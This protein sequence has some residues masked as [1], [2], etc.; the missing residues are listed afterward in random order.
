[1]DLEAHTVL[2]R[3]G[4]YAR[5]AQSAPL[6][7]APHPNISLHGA[8][9]A[10]GMQPLSPHLKQSAIERLGL[11]GPSSPDPA[12]SEDN[13]INSLDRCLVSLKATNINSLHTT[14]GW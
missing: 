9:Y 12:L 14:L 1:M 6:L 5:C 11:P 13:G 7:Y 3:Q 10:A 8:R 4:A 2:P